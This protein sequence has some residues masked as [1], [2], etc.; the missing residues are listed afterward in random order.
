MLLIGAMTLLGPFSIDMY[1]PGFTA[2]ER[3]LGEQGVE[4]T[5]AA[6]LVGIAIGQLIYGPISDRYGRKPPLYV[7]LL[8]YVGAS[9]GCAIATSMAMLMTFR[10]VQALGACCGLVIGRAIVR[11]RCEPHE[12]AR[13][14]S[15]LMLIGALGPMVAPMLGGWVVTAFGWR[16]VFVFLCLLGSVVLIAMHAML[17]ESRNPAHVVPLGLRNVSRSYLRLLKDGSLVGY[18]IAGGFAMGSLLCYVTGAPTVLTATYGLTPEQF[19]WVIG[20]NGIAFM[21]ASRLNI[22]SL[23]RRGPAQVLARAIVWPVLV[24]IAL[25]AA[26]YLPYLPLWFLLI[27][28]FCFFISVGR[29]NP[30]VSALALASHGREAG[31]A[32]SLIGALQSAVA[33]LAAMAIATFNDGTL[34]TLANIMMAG[35]VLCLLSYVLA[36]R[37]TAER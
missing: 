23:T 33:M 3:E 8:L 31:T 11:D 26:T 13:M 35:V 36:R 2:I 30:N 7:G 27:L 1:L 29:V 25:L 32:S 37:A 28:Q 19:G 34:R 22:R 15:T 17:S 9:L 5:M 14:F 6:Y 21:T 18:S 24:G 20:S 12:A 4:R 10:V 16:A